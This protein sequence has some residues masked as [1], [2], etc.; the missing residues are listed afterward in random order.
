MKLFRIL[1]LISLLFSQISIIQQASAENGSCPDSWQIGLRPL[2]ISDKFPPFFNNVSELDPS[3]S[4]FLFDD[5][6]YINYPRSTW[7]LSNYRL[8]GFQDAPKSLPEYASKDLSTLL[9]KL[10]ANAVVYTRWEYSD[11]GS[12]FRQLKSENGVEGYVPALESSIGWDHWTQGVGTGAQGVF[13]EPGFSV[14]TTS[15]RRDELMPGSSLRLTLE[16]KVKDCAKSGVFSTNSIMI[17]DSTPKTVMGYEKLLE[18]NSLYGYQPPNFLLQ[19]KCS[20]YPKALFEWNVSRLDK[21]TYL[22]ANHF[23]KEQTLQNY[24][25]Q[26]YGFGFQGLLGNYFELVDLDGK[27]CLDIRQL[28]YLLL[29]NNCNVGVTASVY[30]YPTHQGQNKITDADPFRSLGQYRV[31]LAATVVSKTS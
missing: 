15:L 14:S 16:V 6:F 22:D 1:L 29:A 25:P 26:C 13:R 10:G 2:T 28:D 3:I 4:K 27:G 7:H 23:S 11:K 24:L 9:D 17:P 5:Y 20:S 21:T 30:L 8:N 18:I 31:L 12:N 19:E